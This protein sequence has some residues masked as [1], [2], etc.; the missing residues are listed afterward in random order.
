MTAPLTL[1]IAEDDAELRARLIDLLGRHSGLDIIA[2]VGDGAAALDIAQDL[3]PD[4]ALLDVRMPVLDGIS[5][6]ERLRE[7]AP[8]VV[9]VLY[10]AFAL[11]DLR[12]R[13]LAVGVNGILSKDL[14]PES[15]AA[16]LLAAYS[17]TR[18]ISPALD[19]P[20]SLVPASTADGNSAFASALDRLPDRLRPVLVELAQAKSNR[21]IAKAL[22]IS[23]G[24]A[25][26]Y[27]SQILKHLGCSS[28]TEVAIR[29][30][31][32]G[33][34]ADAGARRSEGD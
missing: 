32:C 11:P 4:I 17:G 23:E 19:A 2:A 28:R 7:L 34:G 25:R 15:L 12:S 5:T 30:Q 21:E 33:I 26:T 16:N 3:Q 20:P 8:G 18:I 10:T 31:R 24:S 27:V 13:A 9:V 1:L 6:A 29:A 14:P 22:N